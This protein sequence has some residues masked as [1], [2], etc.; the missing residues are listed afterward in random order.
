MDTKQ[1]LGW[2]VLNGKPKCSECDKALIPWS[3]SRPDGIDPL[4]VSFYC[5]KCKK[6]EWIN[7]LV[8]PLDYGGVR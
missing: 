2:K 7:R 5:P 6:V 3:R 1:F 8:L 4:L